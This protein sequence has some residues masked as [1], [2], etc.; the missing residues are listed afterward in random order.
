[1]LWVLHGMTYRTDRPSYRTMHDRVRSVHGRADSHACVGC[2][3]PAHH[4]SYDGTDP[5]ELH[6]R[7]PGRQKDFAYSLDVS[8][9]EPR[10]RSCH[11]THDGVAKQLGV[12]RGEEQTNSKLT[13]ADVRAI[14]GALTVEGVT[15]RSLAQLYD[16]DPALISRIWLRK[17]WS[18]VV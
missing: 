9:Y 15:Q 11:S 12:R 2:G 5:N 10:C 13:E 8:R 1:M 14:R 16:V 4:W 3:G 6:E 18:H 7:W 17:S